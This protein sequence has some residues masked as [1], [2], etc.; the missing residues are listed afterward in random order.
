MNEEPV[1]E[2]EKIQ[3][4]IIPG[5]NMPHQCFIACKVPQEQAF[6]SFLRE[7]VSGITSMKEALTY[8]QERFEKAKANNMYGPESFMLPDTQNLFWLNIGI[9]NTF[10]RKFNTDVETL[11][12]SYKLG[13]AARS[14]LLGD[15]KNVKDK[16][17][18]NNWVFGSGDKEADFILIA[19]SDRKEELDSN[20]SRLLTIL[21]NHHIKILYQETGERLAENKE[22]FGF[23]DGV[24]QPAVRGYI[25]NNK[26]YLFNRTITKGN[27]GDNTPE[28]AE[29][30]KLLVWPGQFIFGYPRQSASHFRNPVPPSGIEKNGFI[31]NGSFLVFRR[32]TQHV[33]EFYTETKKMHARLITTPGFENI[34]FE[35]FQAKLVGRKKDGTHLLLDE[36]NSTHEFINNFN[37]KADTAAY[38]LSDGRTVSPLKADPQGAKCPMF[39]HIRKVN[40]RD[41]PTDQGAESNTATFRI[42]RRGIPFGEPYDTDNPLSAV[43]TKERGLLFA[44]YQT[45]IQN[46]FELLTN[47]WMN[48][49]T[50]PESNLG[51]DIIV[52]QNNEEDTD[53]TRWF[54]Y[55]NAGKQTKLETMQ[56]FV[57]PAGGGYFFCPSIDTLH[58]LA[59]I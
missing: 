9:G 10:L 25:D 49:D 1:L 24:S 21:S 41:L 40:P 27:E 20:I 53:S 48:N 16:G 2:T 12:N 54:T 26:T 6:I 29:P 11:D 8:K 23:R 45:S 56:S 38:T 57:T 37:Y 46:Q 18:R 30:G 42:L 47:K 55:K 3:G 4:N 58:S 31:K 5:F 52:G 15:S 35:D 28:Y 7:I 19:A 22:H 13:L 44:S 33:K 34:S 59:G 43:N 32:L 51:F 50:R 39:A 17:N 14:F 36:E